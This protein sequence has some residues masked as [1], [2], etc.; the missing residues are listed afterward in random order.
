MKKRVPKGIR[1]TALW[2]RRHKLRAASLVVMLVVLWPQPVRSQFLDP[3]CAIITAGLATIS[4]TLTSVVGGGLNNIL[5]VEQ[6]NSSYERNEVWPAASIN[7][8]QG[9]A[10][11]TGGSYQQIANAMSRPVA[12]ATLAAPQQLEQNLLS[13]SSGDITNTSAAYASVYGAVPPSAQASPEV[14][15]MVDM[16]DAVAQDAMKRAI[17]I[18]NLASLELQAAQQLNQAIKTA[19]PGSAPIIEAEADAWLLRANAYTQ[20]A[21]ADLMRVRAVDLANQGEN[22]KLGASTSSA[23]MQK[24]QR[25]LH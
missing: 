11:S 18:D 14:R 8:A 23:M 24:L 7:Q 5:G 15:N 12:S 25:L 3:C 10:A 13:A 20:S 9:V 22:L 17:E 4:R 21:T 19:A 2:V 1:Q 6:A 16:G